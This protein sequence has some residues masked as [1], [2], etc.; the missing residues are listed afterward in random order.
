MR[1]PRSTVSP[2]VTGMYSGGFSPV[3]F[4][5]ALSI[6]WARVEMI[7]LGLR[8]AAQQLRQGAAVVGLQVVE[9]DGA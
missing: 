8:R 2:V 1:S 4:S 9:N 5:S 6:I 3:G 7:Q